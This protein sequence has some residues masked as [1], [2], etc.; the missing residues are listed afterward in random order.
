MSATEVRVNAQSIDELCALFER[1]LQHRRIFVLGRFEL[2]DRQACTLV[3]GHPT[4]ATFSVAAEAVYLKRDEPGAGVGLD[5]IGLTPSALA[6]IKAFIGAPPAAPHATD[7]ASDAPTTQEAQMDASDT[8]SH[9]DSD[10]P[11]VPRNIHERIRQLSLREREAIGRAGNLTERV[12]LERAFGS[13]VWES[14]LQN[15]QLTGPE[16]AHM[17]KNGSLPVPLVNIIVANASWLA[18][19]EV[20][21]ALLSNPRVS[22]H[23]LERVLRALT[24][25]ELKQVAQMSAYRSE[26]RSVAQKLSTK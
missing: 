18:S 3:I 12:A 2:A 16:V 6:E 22:G 24:K 23:N 9:T 14:L 11:K 13:S 7:T 4:G 5:I 8:T 26:V 10:A 15:P 25:V 19:A 1:E 17:A 21:R 20:R